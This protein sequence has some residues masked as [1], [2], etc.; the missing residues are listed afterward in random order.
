MFIVF[1]QK[2]Y[3]LQIF[4]KAYIVVFSCTK[5]KRLLRNIV[6]KLVQYRR[7]IFPGYF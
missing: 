5:G 3:S 1:I 7:M 2:K 6:L 4:L